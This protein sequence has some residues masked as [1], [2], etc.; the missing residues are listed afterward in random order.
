MMKRSRN[1]PLFLGFLGLCLL[2]AMLFRG[3]IQENF[4]TPVAV[5]LQLL[6]RIVLSVDQKYY[7]SMLVLAVGFYVLY[8]P[9]RRSADSAQDQPPDFN[10]NPE[11]ID[12]WRTAILLNS[13]E[14]DKP[15][16]LNHD[17]GQ[18]LAALYA[19]KQPG[20]VQYEI[21]DALKLRQIP[22]PEHIHAFLF[23]NE[24]PVPWRNL[25]QVLQIL[26]QMPGK[27]LRRLMGLDRAGYYQS[28]EEAIRFMESLMEIK[29]DD[30]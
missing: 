26:G 16:I 8:R 5:I 23:P 2:L 28:L 6:W 15:G 24:L 17:L 19:L 20:S 21:Y 12:H 11:N 3:F 27:W 7:W 1:T 18:M 30:E 13:I 10:A 4:V 29:C 9:A 25:N 22:L 14:P